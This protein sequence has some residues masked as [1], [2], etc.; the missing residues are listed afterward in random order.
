MIRYSI[1][2]TGNIAVIINDKVSFSVEMNLCICTKFTY[3]QCSVFSKFIFTIQIIFG[4]LL[5]MPAIFLFLRFKEE[6]SEKNKK[7][8]EDREFEISRKNQQ[9]INVRKSC[10]EDPAR[11]FEVAFII[12]IVINKAPQKNVTVLF[13]EGLYVVFC[14]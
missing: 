4:Y 12:F 7:E 13:Q 11:Q 6:F 3:N 14:V 5:F 2:Q 10:C 8:K 9:I 1:C